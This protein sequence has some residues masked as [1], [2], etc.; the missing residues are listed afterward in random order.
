MRSFAAL[1]AIDPGFDPRGVLSA[2]VSL[3]GTAEAP[4]GRREAFYTSTLE[5]VRQLPGVESASLINHLPIAGDVWGLQ[6]LIEGRPR[7]RPAEVPR[8]TFRVV[9]PGYFTTMRLPILRGRDVA[10]TDRVG[11]PR[12]VV[13]NDLF[14][15]RAWP[16]EEALGKRVTFNPTAESPTW[17]TV[18][19]VVKN[20][21]QSDWAAPPQEEVFL[22]YLQE[23][24][25]LE[26]DGGH[27]GYMTLV[28]RASCTGARA[29]HPA[30]LAPVLRDAVGSLD[31]SVPVTDIQTMEDVI[32]GANARPRFT[33]VLLATFAAL[34][35]VLAAVGIYGVISYAVSRRTHEIGVRVALGASPATVVSLIIA[36][37]MRV[38]AVGVAIGLAGALVASRLMTQLVYGVRVTD[39]TT[40]AGVAALL[41]A[42]ALVAS[43]IPARRATRIDPLV[44]MRAD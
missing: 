42:V 24:E 4:A 23:R 12:V 11:A 34:A 35:L 40:Y 13:V 36:Q 31:R 32:A 30:S 16:N 41:A 8:T 37:S 33:L 29:C 43:Y 9:Y 6:F 38:V 14:A 1:R 20:D 2:V 19:G 44:A 26:T 17:F 27:V 21:V 22:P 10:E 5:R 3:Y 25:Y 39:P 15:R 28:V 7:P 18:V